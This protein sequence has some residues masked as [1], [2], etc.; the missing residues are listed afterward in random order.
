MVAW[1]RMLS[2]PASD[3]RLTP[4]PDHRIE[5]IQGAR[6]RLARSGYRR[7]FQ[8]YVTVLLLTAVIAVGQPDRR[9]APVL[10]SAAVHVNQIDYQQKMGTPSITCQ[11]RDRDP[12]Y[13]KWMR[14]NVANYSALPRCGIPAVGIPAGGKVPHSPIST[15]HAHVIRD[16]AR[17]SL[18]HPGE[19]LLYNS[20]PKA[21]AS[22]WWRTPL[23][24]FQRRDTEQQRR[25]KLTTPNGS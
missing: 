9:P 20:W 5:V 2:L 21:S 16:R 23:A 15:P 7:T 18:Q 13:P 8:R 3:G 6:K 22:R 17:R 25:G 4:E 10:T 1:F 19:G 12:R 24:G 11:S 14:R